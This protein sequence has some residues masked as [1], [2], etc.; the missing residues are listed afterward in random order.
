M[1]PLY[2]FK[3]IKFLVVCVWCWAV[4]PPVKFRIGDWRRWCVPCKLHHLSGT[5][6][7][8]LLMVWLHT[9]PSSE[10]A[11]LESKRP[12]LALPSWLRNAHPT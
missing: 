7:S 11:P 4:S 2:T 10:A 3:L 12:T 9:F 5:W 6:R 1:P 8:D